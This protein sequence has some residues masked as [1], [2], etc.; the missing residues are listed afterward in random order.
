MFSLFHETLSNQVLA[1]F[2]RFVGKF[3]PPSISRVY[4]ESLLMIMYELY[5][6][7]KMNWILFSYLCRRYSNTITISP[8]NQKPKEGKFNKTSQKIGWATFGRVWER[9]A[10]CSWCWCRSTQSFIRSDSIYV[11]IARQWIQMLEPTSQSRCPC[12]FLLFIETPSLIHS[13][14]TL[15]IWLYA[16]NE[17]KM[18]FRIWN[19]KKIFA[20]NSCLN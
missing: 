1:E 7:N 3:F 9:F 13:P 8:A 18:L 16:E 12:L 19:Y 17:R 15:Y 5:K 2:P 4:L 11:L 20:R 14:F 10:G 6:C